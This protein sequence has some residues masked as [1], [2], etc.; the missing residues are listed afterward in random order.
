[1]Q[2]GDNKST[3][4]M[5]ITGVQ[6]IFKGCIFVATITGFN[7]LLGKS[8]KAVLFGINIL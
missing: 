2:Y 4:A 1:M 3:N 5:H 8:M 7:T 6:L